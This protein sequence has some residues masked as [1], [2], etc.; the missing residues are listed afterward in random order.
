MKPCKYK[1]Y[2]F[3]GDKNPSGFK[4]EHFIFSLWAVSG[5]TKVETEE[6]IYPGSSLV[7]EFGGILGLFLGFSFI[8]VW[9]KLTSLRRF[10]C[11][12]FS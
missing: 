3:L 9:D 2:K 5:K 11:I 10:G 12:N 7:A 1:R 4:S 8:S 6:L